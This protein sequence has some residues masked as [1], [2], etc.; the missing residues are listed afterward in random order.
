MTANADGNVVASFPSGSPFRIREI[1]SYD[2]TL[3][4]D[5]GLATTGGALPTGAVRRVWDWRKNPPFE[6]PVRAG[7]ELR[8]IVEFAPVFDFFTMPAG[9]YTSTLDVHGDAW[10]VKVPTTGTLRGAD[11]AGFVIETDV[12]ELTVATWYPT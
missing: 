8:V 10:H 11:L 6:L 3:T 5:S 12:D 7:Q 9:T 1:V 2:G 4:V